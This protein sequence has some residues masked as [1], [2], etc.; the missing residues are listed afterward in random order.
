M[1]LHPELLRR[2]KKR[3]NSI[4]ENIDFYIT[5]ANS[6]L[7]FFGMPLRKQGVPRTSG[8]KTKQGEFRHSMECEIL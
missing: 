4:C 1:G 6:P 8:A 5:G 7:F 2:K 3:N